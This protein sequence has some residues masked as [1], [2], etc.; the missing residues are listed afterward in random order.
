MC[1][2]YGKWTLAMVPALCHACKGPPFFFFLVNSKGPPYFHLLCL[3]ELI[4]SYIEL[5][6]VLSCILV[7]SS[8][9]VGWLKSYPSAVSHSSKECSDCSITKIPLFLERTHRCL[10]K[11][12]TRTLLIVTQGYSCEIRGGHRG[13]CVYACTGSCGV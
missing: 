4:S 1:F 13:H 10:F 5:G 2:M 9:M 6:L 11:V 12:D 7:G 8:G 3:V